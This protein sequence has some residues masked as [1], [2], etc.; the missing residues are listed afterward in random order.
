MKR[1]CICTIAFWIAWIGCTAYSAYVLS[2]QQ[3]WPGIL[4][5]LFVLTFVL[6]V[7]FTILL[8]LQIKKAGAFVTERMNR[9]LEKLQAVVEEMKDWRAKFIAADEQSTILI[10]V[11][12]KFKS[13]EEVEK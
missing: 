10:E 8:V 7:G 3:P 9:S 13:S 12:N 1:L 6:A 5:G 2:Q 4:I 11:L